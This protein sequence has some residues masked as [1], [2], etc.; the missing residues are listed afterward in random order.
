MLREVG[1]ALALSVGP[2]LDEPAARTALKALVEEGP[3]ELVYLRW[4]GAPDRGRSPAEL[5][6][7]R[8]HEIRTWGEQIRELEAGEVFA[9]FNNDY[10][11]HS[12]ASARRL[13]RF[14]GQAP[15]EPSELSPQQD[16]FQ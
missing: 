4:L 2:W 9:F 14:L 11:G 1:V 7:E 15:V 16:L 8:D 3:P 10:Q 6:E 13:Q 12:P 5:V